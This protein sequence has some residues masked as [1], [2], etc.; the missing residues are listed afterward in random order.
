MKAMIIGLIVFIAQTK[1]LQKQLKFHTH[2]LELNP[3]YAINGTYSMEQDKT[4]VLINVDFDIVLEFRD[5]SVH[6][7][8]YKL[9]KLG[10]FFILNERIRLCD[11]FKG[12]KI[13]ILQYFTQKIFKIVKDSTNAIRC[14][15]EV[16]ICQFTS[17]II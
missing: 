16:F 8:G 7:E 13:S 5:S 11:I 12:T 14:F 9:T 17:N 1:S 3:R 6:L 4:T 10:K 15:Y 2:K